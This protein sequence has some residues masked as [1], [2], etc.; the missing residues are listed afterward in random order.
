[1]RAVLDFEAL[2]RLQRVDWVD[3]LVSSPQAVRLRRGA[4]AAGLGW[5]ASFVGQ[6]LAILAVLLAVPLMILG[7]LSPYRLSLSKF[8]FDELYQ[9]LVVMPLRAIAYL[10]D[11]IDRWLVDG[12]VD[13]CGR[14]PVSMGS[15]LRTMQT[16]VVQFYAL[17]MA[18]GALVLLAAGVFFWA[19]G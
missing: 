16:G 13:L 10:C 17:A 19:A 14:A 4:E 6:L 18:L 12:L 11:V 3:W 1:L 7:Y 2:R 15:L 8:F 5:L 9:V